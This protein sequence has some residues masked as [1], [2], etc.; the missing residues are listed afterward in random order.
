MQF[1]AGAVATYNPVDGDGNCSVDSYGASS[2]AMVCAGATWHCVTRLSP[3]MPETFERVMTCAAKS[4]AARGGGGG[5]GAF[6]GAGS[7]LMQQCVNDGK[8]A[9]RFGVSADPAPPKQG[10][11]AALGAGL[12]A[13]V[14]VDV[15]NHYA[16][17]CSFCVAHAGCGWCS[18]PVVYKDGR[19]GSRCAGTRNADNQ[20]QCAGTFRTESCPIGYLCNTATQQCSVGV[21][22]EGIPSKQACEQECKVAPGPPGGMAGNWRGL[23]TSNGYEFGVVTLTMNGS[24]FVFAKVHNESTPLPQRS[25]TMGN[26][27]GV[28]FFNFTAAPAGGAGASQFNALYSTASNSLVDYMT[29]AWNAQA[30]VTVVPAPANYKGPMGAGVE[31]VLAKCLKD[32]CSW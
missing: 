8:C 1:S 5:G 28:L 29:V 10:L 26:H 31:M 25:G 9:F 17:N 14:P 21:P 13:A 32:T 16:T 30:G 2:F 19:P 18:T 11:A 3:G 15:C 22:G 4:F 20:F 6:I 12:A 7:F 24:S 27:D 23:V